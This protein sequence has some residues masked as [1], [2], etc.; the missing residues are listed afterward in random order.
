MLRN[1]VFIA[2]SRD[3]QFYASEVPVMKSQTW[4][5]RFKLEWFKIARYLLF[6]NP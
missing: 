3:G 1:I 4:Y 5:A 6:I 2:I